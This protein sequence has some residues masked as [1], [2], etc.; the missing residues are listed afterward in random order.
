LLS[1]GRIAA[2]TAAS[3]YIN[4]IGLGAPHTAA[5]ATHATS[6]LAALFAAALVFT[7]NNNASSA[8]ALCATTL[9]ISPY[10]YFYD[11][12]LLA[13]GAALLGA[14]RDRFELSAQILA[15]SAGLTL[16]LGALVT[17]PLA[18]FAAWVVLFAAMRRAGI[19]ASR[20][21]PAP[22]T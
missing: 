19:A 6:A 16:A 17:L 4:L 12:T 7:R 15:W 3:L 8:A 22:R 5:M 9:L 1:Q 21:A 10:L 2:D 13:A 11:V 20:P 18:P 14:P